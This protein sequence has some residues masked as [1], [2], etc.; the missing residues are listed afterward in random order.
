MGKKPWRQ[1]DISDAHGKLLAQYLG[2]KLKLLP[3]GVGWAVLTA[4]QT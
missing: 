3:E 1:A 4:S 2:R